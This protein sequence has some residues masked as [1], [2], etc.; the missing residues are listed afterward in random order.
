MKF[1]LKILAGCSDTTF[2][3]F[4]LSVCL[5]LIA[6]HRKLYLTPLCTQLCVAVLLTRFLRYCAQYLFP[7][8][9]VALVMAFPPPALPSFF[10]NIPSSDFPTVISC[11]RFIITCSTYSLPVKELSGSP[12]L[13]LIPPVQHAMLY[14]PEAA[15]QHWSYA[16][17]SGDFQVG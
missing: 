17:H 5:E 15:L 12:Q 9:T 11:P 13:P 6:V 8:N 1:L 4:P 3:T 2:P 7:H 14:N 16:P 10:G